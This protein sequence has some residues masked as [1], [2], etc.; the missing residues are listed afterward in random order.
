MQSKPTTEITI[1][2]AR[3]DVTCGECGEALGCTRSPVAPGSRLAGQTVAEVEAGLD[4]S[5]MSY[6][7]GGTA[8]LHP[9][10][11]QVLRAGDKITVLATL[12]ILKQLD[13]LNRPAK[14]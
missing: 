4:I 12:E 9:K 7:G 3:R 10:P 13:G 1:F 8:D 5:V 2:I 14:S 11:A 6:E